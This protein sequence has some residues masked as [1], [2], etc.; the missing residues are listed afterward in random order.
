MSCCF[1]GSW[2]LV[3][4]SYRICREA[5]FGAG[6][7]KCGLIAGSF[8]TRGVIGSGLLHLLSSGV[9][10]RDGVGEESSA[11]LL[12]GLLPPWF[13]RR[14]SRGACPLSGPCCS[15]TYLCVLTLCLCHLVVHCV[16][17][18]RKPCLFLLDVL[19]WTLEPPQRVHRLLGL[20]AFVVLLLWLPFCG[21]G[22]SPRCLR[23]QLRGWIQFSQ[24]FTFGI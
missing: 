13:C 4:V 17:F 16:P 11:S 6:R 23:W 24:P 21:T 2:S 15:C 19:L 20:T 9:C 3:V 10:G 7:V 18:Q 5:G 14:S 12:S 1:S 8:C 22:Q